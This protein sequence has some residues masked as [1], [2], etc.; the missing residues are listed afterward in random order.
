MNGYEKHLKGF[1]SVLEEWDQELFDLIG[2]KIEG[3]SVVEI[4]F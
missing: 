2:K 1:L 3:Y 4:V